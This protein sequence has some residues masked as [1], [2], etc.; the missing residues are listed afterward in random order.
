LFKHFLK[1]GE[2]SS[3]FPEPTV[4]VEEFAEQPQAIPVVGDRGEHVKMPEEVDVTGWCQSSCEMA[5][6][7]C[8]P[9][10]VAFERP[11]ALLLAPVF[12]K[13]VGFIRS[14]NK[15]NAH[16]RDRRIGDKSSTDCLC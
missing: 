8:Q 7:Q 11:L 2:F 15:I 5:L 1:D 3:S 6:F 14:L 16:L 4:V 12:R 9:F 13:G 10:E